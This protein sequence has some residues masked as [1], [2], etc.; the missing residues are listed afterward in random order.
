MEELDYIW[1]EEPMHEQKMNL[2]QELCRTLTIPV[3]AT[4]M[5]CHDMDLTAQWLIQ[6][7]TDRLRTRTNIGPDPSTQAG[8]FRRAARRQRG[9]ARA[10]RTLRARPCPCRLPASTTPTS[11]SFT[12]RPTPGACGSEGEEWG[13][14]NA[15]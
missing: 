12:A 13:L 2:Y 8:P 1:L 7:A 4:E 15:R 14:L 11:T 9:T 5:L 3:M 6:G 10:G